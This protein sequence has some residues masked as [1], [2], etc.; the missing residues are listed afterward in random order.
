MSVKLMTPQQIRNDLKTIQL[1]WPEG[2]PFEQIDRVTALKGELKR[3]GEPLEAPAEEV[4]EA[5][6]PLALASDDKLAAELRALSVVVGR[7]PNDERAQ[8]RFADIRFEIRKRA[9]A[10]ADQSAAPTLS[11]VAPREL[12]LPS[13][14]EV[15]PPPKPKAVAPRDSEVPVYAPKPLVKKAAIRDTLGGGLLASVCGF[16][17][18]ARDGAVSIS[19]DV[20]VP[21]GV[22][23][24]TRRMTLR[25]VEEFILMIADARDQLRRS[26][27]G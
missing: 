16:A 13:D 25:Q 6:T 9:K 7:N 21:G 1:T 26:S 11:P 17:A 18:E 4:Q 14:D 2:I 3:R 8:S 10:A 19:Y 23:S 12:E 22:V 5:D 20:D 27:E 24:P 15:P